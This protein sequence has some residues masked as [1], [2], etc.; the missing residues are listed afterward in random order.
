M[1]SVTESLISGVCSYSRWIL[2]S[3]SLALFV[4]CMSNCISKLLTPSILGF[5]SVRMFT[6]SLSLSL[7]F[8]S[9]SFFVFLLWVLSKFSCFSSFF[10]Y[11]VAS[12]FC[13]SPFLSGIF[14]LT[15]FTD[16]FF[17]ELLFFLLFL[18]AVTFLCKLDESLAVTTS[19]GLLT[20]TCWCGGST[21]GE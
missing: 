2:Q 10:L 16:F 19:F 21:I 1:A 11:S 17:N 12:N 18:R 5:K 7:K 8:Q 3:I 15:I 9:K 13:L 6:R 14:S 4:T 20:K